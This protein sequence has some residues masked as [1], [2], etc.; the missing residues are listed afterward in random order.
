[1]SSRVSCRRLTAEGM[2]RRHRAQ[3]ARQV[4][5]GSRCELSRT[6]LR[7]R[8]SHRPVRTREAGIVAGQGSVHEVCCG[9]RVAALCATAVL[10]CSG[11]IA[12]ADSASDS[13]APIPVRAL[14]GRAA[15]TRWVTNAPAAQGPGRVLDLTVYSEAMGRTVPI[16][17][18]PAVDNSK[19]APSCICSMAS[20]AVLI[21]GYIALGMVTALFIDAT[22]LRMLLVPATMK[23]LGDACRW[24]PAWVRRIQRNV[25][26]REPITDRAEVMPTPGRRAESDPTSV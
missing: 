7:Q 10:A 4:D 20:T 9:P 13:D 19:P 22:V 21:P 3:G 23:L 12:F 1:M 24:A 18:I 25:I 6:A 5:S 17:V 15:G 26:V 2:V 14:A 8:L 11:G 16:E